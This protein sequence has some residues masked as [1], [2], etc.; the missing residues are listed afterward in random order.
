MKIK[1][2]LNLLIMFLINGNEASLNRVLPQKSID[3]IHFNSKKIF[4]ITY[5]IN[6]ILKFDLN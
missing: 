3:A 4:I 1:R 2:T 5:A 6:Y